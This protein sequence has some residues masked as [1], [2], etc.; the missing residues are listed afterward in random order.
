MPRR[1]LFSSSSSSSSSSS[2]EPYGR[3]GPPTD[4]FAPVLSPCYRRAT[5]LNMGGLGSGSRKKKGYCGKRNCASSFRHGGVS[6]GRLVFKSQRSDL[7]ESN[8]YTN[9]IGIHSR[10][11]LPTSEASSL[12]TPH[13][14]P[15][16]PPRFLTRRL[17][18]SSNRPGPDVEVLP[19][20]FHP[21]PATICLLFLDVFIKNPSNF[22]YTYLP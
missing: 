16:L 1:H 20:K 9:G 19:L 18:W 7:I 2:A 5:L 22:I 4:P 17:G 21:T 6:N 8:G 14:P 10:W 15:P 11:P 13:P 3:R 12:L